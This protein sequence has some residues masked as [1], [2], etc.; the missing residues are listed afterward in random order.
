AANECVALLSESAKYNWLEV[1]SKKRTAWIREQ[2]SKFNSKFKNSKNRKAIESNF[3]AANQK[4]VAKQILVLKDDSIV[5]LSKQ[6]LG[7]PTEIMLQSRIG[8]EPLFSTG[9]IKKNNYIGISRLLLSPD[10]KTLAVLTYEAGS[11]DDYKI[12]FIDLQ[13]KVLLP[14]QLGVTTSDSIV[15]LSN[16]EIRAPINEG[17]TRRF[18]DYNINTGEKKAVESSMVVSPQ[19]GAWSIH[20][21]TGE[22]FAHHPVYG[23]KKLPISSPGKI[24]FVDDHYIYLSLEMNDTSFEVWRFRVS[25]DINDIEDKQG[26]G[27]FIVSVRGWVIDNAQIFKD[28]IFLMGHWG[29]RESIRIYSSDGDDLGFV[30]IPQYATLDRFTVKS[31]QSGLNLVLHLTNE[32]VAEKQYIWNFDREEWVGQAPQPDHFLKRADQEY[33]TEIIYYD[34]QSVDGQ[35]TQVPMRLTYR[36]DLVKDQS[37]AVLMD[38]YGGFATPSHLLPSYDDNRFQFLKRGGILA[39]PA[40]RGGNEFGSEWHNDGRRNNKPNTYYDLIE[41]SRW[42]QNQKW[43]KAKNIII[44]G[45][46]NGGLTVS[47]AALVSL[48]SFGLVISN[49]GVHDMLR[50]EVI[51]AGSS[52][53][54]DEYGDSRNVSDREVLRAYSPLELSRNLQ[55]QKEQNTNKPHFL[56]L[57]GASDSRVNPA[58]SYKFTQSL[59]DAGFDVQTS[60]TKNAG[61]WG[62][63]YPHQDMVAWRFHTVI[64]STIYDYLGWEY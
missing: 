1:D 30:P 4:P 26:S 36:K 41:A 64:W 46:S 18:V 15:W 54:S 60:I 31:D 11:I 44:K 6:G 27:Q 12:I 50:K 58:H 56:I 52:G 38:V 47:A 53:W 5:K 8:V 37:N 20:M 10:E 7:W 13:S 63:S 19:Y 24:L 33:I 22:Y 62:I 14:R 35:S 3:I 57:V 23:S 40:L 2:N 55:T 43:A 29:A 21:Q 49:N 42:L 16:S 45:M 28:K 32:I 51:D 39:S 48:E 9:W 17:Q 34:S 59:I 25:Y 61:H